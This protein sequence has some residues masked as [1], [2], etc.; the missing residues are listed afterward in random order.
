MTIR[1]EGG[2]E[3]LETPEEIRSVWDRYAGDWAE[4][5]RSAFLSLP[6]DA[7]LWCEGLAQWPTVKWEGRGGTV[8]L[9]G[10][11]AHPMTYRMLG[12]LA[13][14]LCLFSP[15]SL[16]SCSPPLILE[17]RLTAPLDRGQGLNNAVHDACTLCR[18]LE[19]H[20]S[21]G[22]PLAEAMKG[23]EDEVVERGHEAVVASG[24]NSLM[25]HDVGNCFFSFFGG[26]S[27][28]WSCF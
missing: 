20:L 15:S 24:Q 19:G 22:T 7:T 1:R 12:P 28:S 6:G 8:T 5:F 11:A 3:G 16:A 10:D 9:A 4:P 27:E 17:A 13:P 18:A 2:S 25:I 21:E 26:L 14:F 23:Y